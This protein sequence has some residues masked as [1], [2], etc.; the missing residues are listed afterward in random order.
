MD[1]EVTIVDEGGRERRRKF[2]KDAWHIFLKEKHLSSE[3]VLLP[4]GR[5]VTREPST[6]ELD[7]D[8]FNDY[9]TKVEAY[10]SETFGVFLPD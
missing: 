1:V 10:A 2:G 9:M 4:S 6:S 5:L 7:V 3:D 8:Q